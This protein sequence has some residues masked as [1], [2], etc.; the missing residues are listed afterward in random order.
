MVKVKICGI[1][2]HEDLFVS[3]EEGT[4]AVGFIFGFPSSPRNLS[5]KNV[6]ELIRNVPVFV[7]SVVV[8]KEDLKLIE[9]VVKEANPDYLQLYGVFKIN[10]YKDL[11]RG[12]K[13]IKV[14]N[15]DKNAIKL[16]KKAIKLG[17]NVVMLDNLVKGMGGSGKVADW[18]LC[19]E[20]R[21]EIFPK[22]FIL[23]GGL[24]KDNV[25]EAI[26]I[27]NPYAVDAS[28]SLEVSKGVKDAKLI[29]E[30]I[31]RVKNLQ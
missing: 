18:N 6:K 1:K 29:R 4:D 15:A 22:P 14:L 10:D 20:V 13:L 17:Y 12:T 8:T 11:V 24:R 25:L 7:D 30:F 27:V 3:V 5:I 2:R 31:K 16:A 21:D 23:S 26:K 19:K 28:S 9:L